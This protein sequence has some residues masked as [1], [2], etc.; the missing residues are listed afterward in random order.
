MNNILTIPKAKYEV[1][2][3]QGNS[4]PVPVLKKIRKCTKKGSK[5]RRILKVQVIGD[6]EFSYHATRGWKKNLI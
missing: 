4:G 1:T 5:N 3:F 6:Y 2:Y